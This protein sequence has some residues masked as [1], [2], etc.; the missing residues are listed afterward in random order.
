MIISGSEESLNLHKLHCGS[1][2]NNYSYNYWKCKICHG[3]LSWNVDTGRFKF[4]EI[5]TMVYEVQGY[6]AKLN[7]G[8]D[9]GK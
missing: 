7:I 8:Y 4:I 9:G 2:K 5:K 6:N 1:F 3:F